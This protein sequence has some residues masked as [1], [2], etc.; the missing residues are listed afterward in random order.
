MFLF[1]LLPYFPVNK[2]YVNFYF[3][4]FSYFTK[5]VKVVFLYPIICIP[6]RPEERITSLVHTYKKNKYKYRFKTS[7]IGHV[8]IQRTKKNGKKIVVDLAS[9]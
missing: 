7:F 8:F 2:K 3:Y 6:K 5:K 9:D 1:F 4:L